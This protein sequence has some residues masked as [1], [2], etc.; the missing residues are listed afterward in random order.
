MIKVANDPSDLLIQF[1]LS[2]FNLTKLIMAG[3]PLTRSS[4]KSITDMPAVVVKW[5][6]SWSSCTSSLGDKC[7]PNPITG[8]IGEL[9]AVTSLLFSPF[10]RP[11]ELDLLRLIKRYTLYPFDAYMDSLDVDVGPTWS[12]VLLVPCYQSLLRLVLGGIL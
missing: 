12:L 7:G 5:H 11:A 4:L 1:N 2:V 3:K 10:T 9:K 6:P 8:V